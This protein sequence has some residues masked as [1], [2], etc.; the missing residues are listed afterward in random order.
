MLSVYGM[1]AFVS[2]L[3][4]TRSLKGKPYGSYNR[5][6]NT[7]GLSKFTLGYTWVGP[8][9]QTAELKS[10]NHCRNPQPAGC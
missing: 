1:S 4:F 10:L 5:E 3:I 9:S 6:T 2:H 7:G 8:D